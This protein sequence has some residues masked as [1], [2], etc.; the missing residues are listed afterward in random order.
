MAV[1]A[2][3]APSTV[4][5]YDF[6]VD[7]IY[8]NKNGTQATVTY[9]TRF[10]TYSGDVIIPE[11]VTYNGITY[12]VT[13]IG[14]GAFNYCTSPTRV[15]IPNTVTTFQD[16]AF[17][18]CEGLMSVNIPSSIT[19]I[20]DYV[21]YGCDALPSLE[22]PSSVTK[23]GKYAL[24]N[25]YSLVDL[26]LPSSISTISTDAFNS[27]K[28]TNVHIT[29]LKAWCKISFGNNFSNPLEYAEN[30]YVN[31]ELM[32]D[33][34]LPETVTTIK[35][36]AFSGFQG[37]TSVTIPSS[38]TY[39]G[40]NV[41][42][43]CDSLTAVYINDL[44]AWCKISFYS[45]YSN[46]LSYAHHL[47]LNGEEIKDLVIPESV[48]S[49]SNFAFSGGSNFTSVTFHESLTR[50]GELTFS[51]CT[52][53]TNLD[54]PE[55]LTSIGTSAFAACKGLTSIYIPKSVTSIG[56]RAFYNSPE[57]TS[58]EV[59]PD[60]PVYDSR[61]NCNAIIKTSTNRLMF[62]C[63]NTVIP[64]T[65]TSIGQY[66]FMFCPALTSIHIPESVTAINYNA[67]TY[68]DGLTSIEIGNNVTRIGNDA[69]R[70]CTNL[71]SVSIGSGVTSIGE[72]AFAVCPSITRMIC[73][74]ATPPTVSYY[75]PCSPSTYNMATLFVPEASLQAY[76]DHQAWGQFARIVPFI[77]EGPGDTNGDGRINISDAILLI[78]KLTCGEELPAYVDVNGDGNMDISDC[79]ALIN[80]LSGAN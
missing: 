42:T 26:T 24:S 53:L 56:E 4:A 21:F 5:A 27:S 20:G 78:S 55:S 29:D 72:S 16:E 12:T 7:G 66:A 33:L 43:S 22:I 14:T 62:G 8:Y 74:A 40:N 68:C 48:T 9:K 63:Q 17:M 69:F 57:V 6:T 51:N 11:T 3:L 23:I 44:S 50:I 54:F 60:N 39:I 49:I 28:I 32:N 79:I 67:F 31:G 2:A 75:G 37:L 1:I 15:T 52:G 70:S 18:N 61:D 19:S 34:V 35:D 77:G 25:C 58:V 80:M 71:A 45:Y 76:A 36:Y 13:A 10:N 38:V 30:L 41:F 65:V 59:S 46:P 64:E 47:Y 73:K